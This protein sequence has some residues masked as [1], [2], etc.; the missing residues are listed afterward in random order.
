ME[1]FWVLYGLLVGYYI[2]EEHTASTIRAELCSSKMA[3]STYKSTQWHNP[4]DKPGL[5]I[6]IRTSNLI[7]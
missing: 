3:V 4:E 1:V 6:A 2:L 7:Q 5:F